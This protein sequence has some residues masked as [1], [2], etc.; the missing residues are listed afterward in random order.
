MGNK[1][2]AHGVRDPDRVPS[3]SSYV[4]R[5][6]ERRISRKL[7]FNAALRATIGRS[8]GRV[9]GVEEDEG[10]SE[11]IPSGVVNKFAFT[12]PVEGKMLRNLCGCAQP[13]MRV[14]VMSVVRS[15]GKRTLYVDRQFSVHA[16][17]SEIVAVDTDLKMMCYLATRFDPHEKRSHPNI[18]ELL[19]HFCHANLLHIVTKFYELGNLHEMLL[20]TSKLES[21][22]VRSMAH[23]RSDTVIRATLRDIFQGV[24]FIHRAGI[25]HLDLALENIYVGFDGRCRVG[26]FRHAR[27]VGTVNKLRAAPLP[28]RSVY[29]APELHSGRKVD[30]FKADAWS[31]GIIALMVLTLET[32]LAEATMRDPKYQVLQLCGVPAFIESVKPAADSQFTVPQD[33]LDMLSGLLCCNPEHR[34]SVLHAVELYPWLQAG[35]TEFASRQVSIDINACKAR[36][37]DA[38]AETEPETQAENSTA[39]HSEHSNALEEES[40]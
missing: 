3:L 11:S 28:T 2:A 10:E 24:A 19:G 29:A 4:S 39:P 12:R 32:P 25:A 14:D 16:Q 36:N 34:S 38:E 13:H 30:L 26:D 7:S 5:R 9:D 31:L 20:A 33:M 21:A 40:T 37:A 27:F 1:V 15:S 35:E 6:S 18:I 23:F 17:A 8:H 22:N